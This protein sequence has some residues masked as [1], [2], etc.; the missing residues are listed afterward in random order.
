MDEC[1]PLAM[2]MRQF[3]TG[4]RGFKETAIEP[5]P[6]SEVRSDRW[7]PLVVPSSRLIDGDGCLP[8]V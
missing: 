8:L 4:P 1:K 7:L 5:N 6:I 3:D 2:G